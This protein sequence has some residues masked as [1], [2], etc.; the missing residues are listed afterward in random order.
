MHIIKKTAKA[1]VVVSKENEQEVN[2]DKTKYMAMTRVEN[3]G[4]S[5]NIKIDFLFPLKGWKPSN[6]WEQF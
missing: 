2:A 6:I 1:L 5:H 4:Q 3:T